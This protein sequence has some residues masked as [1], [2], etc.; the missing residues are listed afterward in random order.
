[1]NYLISLS[2]IC[3]LFTINIYEAVIREPVKRIR[4]PTSNMWQYMIE[5]YI[6]FSCPS[7]ISNVQNEPEEFEEEFSIEEIQHKPVWAFYYS[8]WIFLIKRKPALW[9]RW[10]PILLWDQVLVIL[11]FF[12]KI[13]SFRTMVHVLLHKTLAAANTRTGGEKKQ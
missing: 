2:S 13:I 11:F 10:D 4:N 6:K 8:S 9:N 5:E 3:W 12:V 7:C 1:M